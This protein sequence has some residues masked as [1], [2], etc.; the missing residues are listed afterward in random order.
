MLWELC[1]NFFEKTQVEKNNHYN[2]NHRYRSL[3]AEVCISQSRLIT[4]L[5]FLAMKDPKDL[6]F[7]LQRCA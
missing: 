1:F 3:H 5:S 4:G 6:S 2:H 7:P